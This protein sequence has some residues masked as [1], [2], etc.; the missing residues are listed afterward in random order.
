MKKLTIL[1]ALCLLL[2]TLP[3]CGEKQPQGLL[4]QDEIAKCESLY[5]TGSGSL[6]KD[7]NL[8]EEDV[9]TQAEGYEG[10]R[11]S[12]VIPLKKSRAIAGTDYQVLLMTAVTQPEGLYGVWFR[13]Q[14]R[15]GEQAK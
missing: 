11:S 7:L 3:A 6:L 15:D 5:L 4:S 8:S 13:V 2:L 12:G 9:D 14:L 10:L 1:L